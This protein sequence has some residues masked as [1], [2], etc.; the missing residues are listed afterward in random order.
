ME[1]KYIVAWVGIVVVTAITFLMVEVY[2]F[3]RNN[4]TPNPGPTPI[5]YL[6]SVR[7]G[8]PD[9]QNDKTIWLKTVTT[10]EF[11]VEPK[12]SIA[13]D[14]YVCVF[15][16]ISYVVWGSPIYLAD[17]KKSITLCGKQYTLIND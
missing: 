13:S 9:N 2:K 14:G 3:N 17:D 5:G 4:A 16:H 10:I 15:G 7:Y 8:V 12:R 6:N 1:V 11:N